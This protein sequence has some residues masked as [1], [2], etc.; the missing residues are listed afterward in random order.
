[1]CIKISNKSQM[2]NMNALTKRTNLIGDKD[3]EI[4]VC[5]EYIKPGMLSV[6]SLNNLLYK[7]D[8][9]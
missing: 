6:D 1:M 3:Y 7:L 4:H 8:Y 5:Y 9:C 2:C